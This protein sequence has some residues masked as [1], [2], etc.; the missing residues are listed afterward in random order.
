MKAKL[1]AF[2]LP[3]FIYLTYRITGCTC[4]EIRPSK[5]F[6]SLMV[7]CTMVRLIAFSRFF[8]LKNLQ[9]D[10]TFL[11]SSCGNAYSLPLQNET[12][13]RFLLLA[14]H[15]AQLWENPDSV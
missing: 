13:D 1:K 6:A 8:S 3:Q 11:F 4:I 12:F 5:T 7:G 9:K 14:S 10:E 15:S 2:D